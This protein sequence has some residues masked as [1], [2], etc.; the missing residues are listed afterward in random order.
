MH[1][2]AQFDRIDIL[3]YLVQCGLSLFEKDKNGSK[4]LHWAIYGGA[5][6]SLLFLLSQGADLEEEDN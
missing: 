3:A 1:V 4:P 5:E 2:A 6:F